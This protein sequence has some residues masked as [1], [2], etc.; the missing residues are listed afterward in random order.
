ME[1]RVVFASCPMQLRYA[2]ASLSSASRAAD[3]SIFPWKRQ[4]KRSCVLRQNPT[5]VEQHI[6]CFCFLKTSLR[7]CNCHSHPARFHTSMPG[8]AQIHIHHSG[9]SGHSDDGG[10]S[11]EMSADGW[12]D[13]GSGD[14]GG[15]GAGVDAGVD[16]D[17]DVMQERSWSSDG[18]S[19]GDADMA[20][21]GGDGGYSDDEQPKE[22]A[23]GGETEG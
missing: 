18:G 15:E 23:G 10:D 8:Q 19:S 3:R 20:M 4:R 16:M 22:D 14:M 21:D 1:L 2:C 9:T 11:S 12:G 17:E 13:G 5:C 6:P 7:V